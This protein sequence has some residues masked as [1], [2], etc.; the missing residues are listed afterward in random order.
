VK[1]EDMKARLAGGIAAL[2]LLTLGACVT[3]ETT[4]EEVVREQPIV[5]EEHV[6]TV[7]QQ[8]VV[9]EEQ[10]TTVHEQPGLHEEHTT[11]TSTTTTMAD[12]HETWWRIHHAGEPYDRDQA[13]VLHRAF[14]DD[15]PGDST[16]VSW[17][18]RQ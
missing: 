3:H 8:P 17:Y 1:E 14:C 18:V 6:T 12:P 13:I 9:R 11:T 10:T 7:Q 5:R 4:H 2:S 15:H 16:C